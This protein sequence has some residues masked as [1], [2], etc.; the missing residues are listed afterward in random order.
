MPVLAMTREIGSLGTHVAQEVAKRLGYDLV[1]QEIIAEAARVYEAD[2]VTLVATVETRP[3]MFEAGKVAARRHFSFVAAE[4]LNAALPD[5]VVIL[6]RWS[7]LLL[8][9]IRHA[10]RVRVC[11]PLDLRAAR[12]T[13]RFK[14]PADEAVHRIRRSDEGI[15]A[16]IRQ[17]FDVE[18]DDPLQYDLTI[19]TACVG[20]EEAADLLISALRQP[21]RQPTDLSRAALWDA[22]LVAR[23]RA[24]LKANPATDQ[25]DITLRCRGGRLELTGTVKDAETRDTVER[26]ASIRAGIGAVDNRLIVTGIPTT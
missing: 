6:G 21:G 18:W 23:V 11:A 5:N 3:R 12:L 7:T 26:L 15:R 14:V 13:R 1:R 8:R 25:T 4:V 2:P 20:V 22:A 17:F 16:R 9:D 24:A 19:N 10:L